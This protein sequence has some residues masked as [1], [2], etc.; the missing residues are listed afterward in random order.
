MH[1]SLLLYW[2]FEL[3]EIIFIRRFNI[4]MT[5]NQIFEIVTKLMLPCKWRRFMANIVLSVKNPVKG[6][7][8]LFL[9]PNHFENHWNCFFFFQN[10][11]RKR[12]DCLER[13]L[14]EERQKL[15]ATEKKLALVSTENISSAMSDDAKLFAREKDLL[16][17]EVIWISW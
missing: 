1:D 2:K 4:N 14:A 5:Q 15:A 7:K 16:Q 12:I 6:F 13:L 17:A 8:V 3:R 10:Q 11:F 9:C